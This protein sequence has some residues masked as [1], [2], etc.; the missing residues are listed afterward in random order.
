MKSAGPKTMAA[1][2]GEAAA[3]PST[4]ASPGVLDLGLEADPAASQPH[5]LLDLGQQHVQRLHLRASLTLGSIRQ[6]RFSPRPRPP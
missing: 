1:M 4:C 6:S 5:R 2:R 3:I